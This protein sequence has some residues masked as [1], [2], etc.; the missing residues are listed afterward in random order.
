MN[1]ESSNLYSVRPGF[2][3]N[4]SDISREMIEIDT[5]N[6]K[7][8][9]LLAQPKSGSNRGSVIVI[10]EI[11]GLTEHIQD[12]ACRF[13][14]AGYNALAPNL[15]CRGGDPPSIAGGFGPLMEYARSI[16]DSQ[17]ISDV[18]SCADYL[19]NLETSNRKTGAVGFCWGGRVCLLAAAQIPHLCASVAYYGRIK[20]EASENQPKA[21]LDLVASMTVPL[22]G[23]FGEIDGGIP[24][25]DV[26]ELKQKFT[27]EGRSPEIYIYPEAGHAF[28]ND[29]R[30]TFNE[31]A[32][33]LAM[34]RTLQ[35]F[36]K[37]LV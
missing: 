9:G 2:A 16:P 14:L 26:E 4:S 1:E 8:S 33:N 11:F 35:W 28:N 29:T 21:P 31:T 7:I 23:H 3:A 6:G 25:K 32:A 15:F 27:E 19:N 34:T 10:H 18:A 13:A 30:E 37:Y 12:V 20:G 24:V 17:V 22:M 36:E 5:P